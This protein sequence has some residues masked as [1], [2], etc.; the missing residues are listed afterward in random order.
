MSQLLAIGQE[1][2]EYYIGL[3]LLIR[4]SIHFGSLFMSIGI[5]TV[6]YMRL[7]TVY[8]VISEGLSY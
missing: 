5:Q 1:I 4:T 2:Y 3:T 8:H 7:A 6:L